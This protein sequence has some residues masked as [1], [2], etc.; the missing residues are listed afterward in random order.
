MVP[1][2]NYQ[3]WAAGKNFSLG[4]FLIFNTDKNHSVVQTY[5]ITTYRKCDYN[6]ADSDDTVE[7]A[8][9]ESEFNRD[10]V[11]LEV[12]LLKEGMTYFFSGD[13]DGDQCKHGQHFKINVTHGQG[14]PESLK[15][16]SE[17]SPAPTSPDDENSV[18]D[19]VIPSNFD[20]PKDDT[21]SVKP[22]SAAGETLVGMRKDGG[23]FILVS[24]LI[25][26]MVVL[27]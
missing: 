25:W 7:W 27:G 2:V 19:N 4:D 8:T 15:S 18:P 13:Y 11:T 1:K 22:T 12:P 20:N 21:G 3:S 23:R 16:P 17:Q 5:N 9:G 10:P 6:D 26:L 24:V 14:L